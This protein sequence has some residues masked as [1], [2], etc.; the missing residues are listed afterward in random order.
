MQ[1][2]RIYWLLPLMALPAVASP[3]A[4]KVV[5]EAYP[6]FLIESGPGLSGPYADAF[7]ILM[8]RQGITVSYQSLPLRRAIQQVANPDTCALAVNFAPGE[9]EIGT[10][11]GRI[12]PITLTVYT[13]VRQSVPLSNIEQLR[14]RSVGAINIAEIRDLLGTAGIPFVP[15][16]RP[17]LGLPMLNAGRFDAFIS[18]A[19]PDITPAGS[20]ARPFRAFTL[21][22]VERWVLCNAGMSPATLTAMRRALHQGVFAEETQSVWHSYGMDAFYLETR[23]QWVQATP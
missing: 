8:S 12:A 1:G 5:A 21:A 13:R 6:P 19:R 14:H 22:R 11:V 15:V 9:A 18:D 10:Y 2:S 7:R 4:I 20:A 23:R 3:A 17:S 16:D